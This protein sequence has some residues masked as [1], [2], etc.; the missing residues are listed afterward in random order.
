[1]QAQVCDNPIFNPWRPRLSS[2]GVSRSDTNA[3]ET[4]NVY[5]DVLQWL[6]R[7]RRRPGS[8]VAPDASRRCRYM[9]LHIYSP[10]TRVEKHLMAYRDQTSNAPVTEWDASAYLPAVSPTAPF[11]GPHCDRPVGPARQRDRHR[12]G[13]RRRAPYRR[14]AGAPARRTRHRHGSLGVHARRGARASGA[15][16][17]L[18]R[19]LCPDRSTVPRSRASCLAVVR[20]TVPLQFAAQ[21]R[22]FRLRLLA[23]PRFLRALLPPGRPSYQPETDAMS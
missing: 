18:A 4:P 19:L 20:S 9:G 11:L 2:Y 3:P 1:M 23:R 7:L 5:P 21:P 15:A 16:L 22:N 13:P 10:I 17:W 14:A 8:A 12:R 6:W